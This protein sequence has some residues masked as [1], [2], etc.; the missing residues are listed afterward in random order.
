MAGA[1]FS[2]WPNG[3]VDM[4]ENVFINVKN[5]SRASPGG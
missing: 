5:K 4:M 1:T 3:M 2:P